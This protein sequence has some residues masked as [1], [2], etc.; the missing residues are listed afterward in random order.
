MVAIVAQCVGAAILYGIA[1][2]QVTA[3]VCV[4]YFTVFHPRVIASDSPTLLALVW[5][6]LATWWV[7]FFLGVPLAFVAQAGPLLRVSARDLRRPTAVLLLVMA[8]LAF[9]SGVAGY[10]L[11]SSGQLPMLP[12]WSNDIPP[13]RHPRFMADLFAHNASYT[14]GFLGGN[15]LLGWAWRRRRRL[16]S[17]QEIGGPRGT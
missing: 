6:V 14:S 8:C 16:A 17:R 7:G 4:E 1:H 2:D 13:T 9:V 11:T 12:R 15:V 5:G 3:R 10:W